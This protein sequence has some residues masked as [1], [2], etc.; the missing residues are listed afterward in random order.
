M[1][2]HKEFD[3]IVNYLSTVYLFCCNFFVL[4]ARFFW[5]RISEYKKRLVGG[6]WD[7]NWLIWCLKWVMTRTFPINHTFN[8]GQNS[9]KLKWNFILQSALSLFQGNLN[10]ALCMIKLR[11]TWNIK[12]VSTLRC[13][14]ELVCSLIPNPKIRLPDKK[15]SLGLK[16]VQEKWRDILR[17]KIVVVT[18]FQLI[19]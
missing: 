16:G 7:K 14:L 18:K 19:W 9:W 6:G 1:C 11:N 4:F 13:S 5:N 3:Y 2:L 15:C 10:A 8:G 12:Y 17:C